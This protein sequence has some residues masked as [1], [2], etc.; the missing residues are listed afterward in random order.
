[1]PAPV[2]LSINNSLNESAL[3][4]FLQQQQIKQEPFSS[5]SESVWSSKP[6]DIL[7]NQLLNIA[8][9]SQLS[10][11]N[12]PSFMNPVELSAQNRDDY[13]VA[14]AAATVAAAVAAS[15]SGETRKPHSFDLTKF[16]ESRNVHSTE[17]TA[18][19]SSEP[20]FRGS[21]MPRKS[22]IQDDIRLGKGRFKLVRKRG[23]S[24]VW[25]LFGQVMDNVTGQKLPFV[26]C[27][28]CKVLYTDT[29]GGTGNMT[30]HRCP[31]GASYRNITGSS[32]DTIGDSFHTQS[33]FESLQGTSPDNGKESPVGIPCSISLKNDIQLSSIIPCSSNSI[34]QSITT[35]RILQTQLSNL[36]SVGSISLQASSSSTESAPPGLLSC[37]SLSL[38]VPSTP[39]APPTLVP[40]SCTQGL[41]ADMLPTNP[42]S[43]SEVEKERMLKIIAQ[44]CVGSFELPSIVNKP[45]FAKLLEGSFEAARRLFPSSSSSHNRFKNFY[46]LLPTEYALTKFIKEE[47]TSIRDK[48]KRQFQTTLDYGIMLVCQQL[49]YA[50]RNM[51]TIWASFINADWEYER[52]CIAAKESQAD[53]GATLMQVANEYQFQN[54]HKIYVTFDDT[55]PAS[56]RPSLPANMVYI[57]NVVQAI[58]E[59]L[60]KSIN[61]CTNISEIKHIAKVYQSVATKNVPEHQQSN[62]MG[63]A[64][65]LTTFGGKAINNETNELI[66]AFEFYQLLKFIRVRFDVLKQNLRETELIVLLNEIGEKE[67][68]IAHSLESFLEPFVD[69]CQA[70]DSNEEPHFH[71]IL[72]E[73]HALIH[74]C[75]SFEE[76]EEED[77]SKTTLNDLPLRL[78]ERPRRRSLRHQKSIDDDPM[79]QIEE[80]DLT[81]SIPPISNNNT[82]MRELRQRVEKQ[83]KQWAKE[84]ITTDHMIATALNPRMRKLPIICSDSERLLTYSTIRQ[85]ASLK[86]VMTPENR[87][88]QNED[89]EPQRKRRHFLSK[90]EDQGMAQDEMDTYLNTNFSPQEGRNSSRKVLEFW[91]RVQT[92]PKMSQYAR[93]ILPLIAAVPPLKLRYSPNHLL[94]CEEFSDMLLLKTSQALNNYRSSEHEH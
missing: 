42:A 51:I 22:I 10:N 37:G 41:T 94:S 8:T 27:Y 45:F 89:Y 40:V 1:L 80:P 74:E 58:N 13:R 29:G 73:W 84:H 92:L 90:L 53:F 38:D 61:E 5:S 83:L 12:L 14:A 75:T 31:L 23:R 56:N 93:A 91:A 81:D 86:P 43:T 26:A 34:S 64:K 59:I 7:A 76:D 66:D 49:H 35:T 18:S 20:T 57:E 11:F 79:L 78:S 9:Q 70:F 77:S 2:P 16:A 55:V 3:R 87:N 4:L 15:T 88:E 46:E 85:N 67:Q 52:I 32:T 65:G 63:N 33:S 44:Y 39:G 25:N 6:T 71:T 48:L 30:R 69:V 82:W 17:S 36:S 47:C 68:T 50:G 19:T 28:A 72:P 62:F 54:A 24:D 21:D 60:I